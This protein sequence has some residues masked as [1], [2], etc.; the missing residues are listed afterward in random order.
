MASEQVIITVFLTGWREFVLGAQA[1]SAALGELGGSADVSGRQM[2]TA[3][4]RSFAFQQEIFTMRRVIYAG[5]LALIGIGAAALKMGFDFDR[6]IQTA[7]VSMQGFLPSTRAINAELD[8]LYNFAAYTPFQ[9]QDIVLA[10][11][12]LIPFTENIGQAN[13]LIRSLVN[14]LSAMGITTQGALNRGSVALAHMLSSGRVTGLAL[15]QL[16]RDNIPL[17]SA[18]AAHFSTTTEEIRRMVSSGL[19]P[20][21]VGAQALNQYI[22]KTP[23]YAGA[24]ARVATRSLTGA[25]TTFKDIIMKSFGSAEGGLFSGLQRT[26]QGVDMYLAPLLQ[27]GKPIT[28]FNLA[29]AFDHV[30]SPKTHVVINAFILFDNVLRGLLWQFSALATIIRFVLWPLSLFGLGTKQGQFGVALLGRALSLVVMALIAYKA[31]VI[32]STIAT[33]AMTVATKGA[34]VATALYEFWVLR[35][36]YAQLL[37]TKATAVYETAMLA[38]MYVTDAATA[39][40]SAATGAAATFSAVLLA[41]PIGLVIAAIALLVGGLVLLYFKWQWFHNLIDNTFHW[42]T[43]HWPLLLAVLT[44]PFGLAVAVII[45]YFA[46][47]KSA[48]SSLIQWV[49]KGFGWLGS[50]VSRAWNHIPG[51]GLLGGIVHHIPGLAAGGTVTAGGMTWLAENGPELVYLPSGARVQPLKGEGGN[52]SGGFDLSGAIQLFQTVKVYLD[53]QELTRSV[54]TIVT[55]KEA[56]L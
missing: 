38:L 28:L 10:T 11:R 48:A 34:A 52:N 21:T 44:G 33:R 1:S 49:A 5:T 26:L 25:W 54:A 6:G 53:G 7:R 41:N 42:I 31:G 13:T 23:G 20:A 16:T 32:A 37:L 14:G 27:G 9:F 17:L 15:N 22:A 29:D 39:A 55:D 8:K 24:A 45:R 30:L 18:L 46:Q 35:A 4:R 36:E 19:I 56:R 51:H 3:G 12:R 2:Q 47:I 43:S 40:L 50:E